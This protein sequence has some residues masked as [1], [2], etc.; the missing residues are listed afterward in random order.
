MQTHRQGNVL[1]VGSEK[2]TQQVEPL[3]ERGSGPNKEG[4]LEKKLACSLSLE[5]DGVSAMYSTF[6]EHNV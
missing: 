5:R 3:R 4:V 6:K 1:H 2:K